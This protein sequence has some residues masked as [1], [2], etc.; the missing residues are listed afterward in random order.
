VRNRYCVSK[1]AL[2]VISD[3]CIVKVIHGNRKIKY[4]YFFDPWPVFVLCLSGAFM[5]ETHC[6]LTTAGTNKEMWTYTLYLM[7]IL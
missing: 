1:P 6:I 7:T 2:P 4:V 5:I 3:S